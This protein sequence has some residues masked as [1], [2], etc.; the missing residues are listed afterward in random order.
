MDLPWGD[1]RT[2]TF[3]TNVGLVASAG[4]KGDNVM[5]CEWAH[6]ISYS[7]ELIAVFL[8][9]DHTTNENIRKT[10]EFGISLCAA[11]QS[12]L[13]SVAGGYS[14]KDYD[15]IAALKELGFEF[16]KGKK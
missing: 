12:V 4:Q 11:D 3:I 8:S 14:G 16:Y 10:K 13:S 2:T 6:Q 5:A 7:P 9:A 1:E 15:K